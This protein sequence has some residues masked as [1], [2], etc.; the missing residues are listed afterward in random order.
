MPIVF[1]CAVSHAPGITA[2]PEAA[3]PERSAPFYAAYRSLGS[4]LAAARCDAIVMFTAEHWT[5]FF[6]DN[7]P[8]FCIGRAESYTGPVETLINIPVCTVPGDPELGKRLLQACYDT[9]IE[10]SFSEE[11]KLDHGTMIPLHFLSPGMDVP[12]VPIFVNALAPPLPALRRCYDLGRAV[13]GAL[14]ATDK[15]VAVVATGGLSHRPG[16]PHTGEV[17]ESFDRAFLADFCATDPER[18]LAG[19]GA[20]VGH[21][22]V[23]TNEVR[24]WLALAGA[25]QGWRGEVLSYEPIPAWTTGCAIVNLVKPG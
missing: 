18:L 11:L 9:G 20:G 24:N 19:L 10:P 23:G 12:V 8:A 7:Y 14:A 2:R 4:V 25:A 21:A 13:G 3:P 17:D 16:T 6:I 22:G 15:R 1:A 5:N